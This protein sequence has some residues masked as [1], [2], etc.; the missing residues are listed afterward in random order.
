MSKKTKQEKP[1]LN[2]HKITRGGSYVVKDGK[3]VKQ[4]L[5][6]QE[7]AKGSDAKSAKPK[8]S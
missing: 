5:K 7:Q 4:D 8:E 6:P 2:P 1:D 3:A